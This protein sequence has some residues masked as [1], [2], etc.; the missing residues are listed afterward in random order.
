VEGDNRKPAP[1][2]Q[3]VGEALESG[4]ETL[5]FAVRGNAERL[6]RTG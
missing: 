2:P 3:K 1:G 5:K 4:V 6:E